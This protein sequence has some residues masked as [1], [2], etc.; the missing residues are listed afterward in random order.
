MSKLYYEPARRIRRGTVFRC[1]LGTKLRSSPVPE[2]GVDGR[3]SVGPR[4]APR[5]NRPVARKVIHEGRPGGVS[6]ARAAAACDTGHYYG[7]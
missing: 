6:G 1:L 7:P 4:G 2:E 5:A 3:G